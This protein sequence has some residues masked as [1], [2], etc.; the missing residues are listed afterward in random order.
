MAKI[1]VDK[2][3][4]L[5]TNEKG[6]TQLLTESDGLK[7]FLKSTGDRTTEGMYPIYKGNAP[8]ASSYEAGL[9]EDTHNVTKTVER[10]T[11]FGWF[12]RRPR[13]TYAF[14][15]S[16]P[17]DSYKKPVISAMKSVLWRKK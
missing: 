8:S 17:A 11:K 16:F 15:V 4:T 13:L 5:E 2:Y 3:F 9:V 7:Q 14:K 1:K 6:M 12:K 10:S